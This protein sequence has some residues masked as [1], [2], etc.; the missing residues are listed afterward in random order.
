[1]MAASPRKAKGLAQGGSRLALHE[2]VLKDRMLSPV[3][4]PIVDQVAAVQL[5]RRIADPHPELTVRST[6]LRPSEY[7]LS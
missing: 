6:A 4:V 2:E 3:R 7:R 1:M 5:L